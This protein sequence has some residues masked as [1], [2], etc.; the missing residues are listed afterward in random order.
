MTQNLIFL[1]K[2]FFC[3]YLGYLQK[4]EKSK[5]LSFDS[6][7]HIFQTFFDQIADFK[8][9]FPNLDSENFPAVS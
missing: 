3:Q 8:R 9:F 1:K 2:Y 4:F 5:V 6:I 7:L